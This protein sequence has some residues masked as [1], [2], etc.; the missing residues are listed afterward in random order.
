MQYKL[1]LAA[2]HGDII[3]LSSVVYAMALRDATAG[4][5]PYHQPTFNG[6][7]TGYILSILEEMRSGRLETCDGFGSAIATDLALI[8]AMQKNPL[9]I[10]GFAKLKKLNE[11][12][13]KRGDSFVISNEGL[14]WYDERGYVQPANQAIKDVKK[15]NDHDSSIPAPGATPY[16]W[17]SRAKEIGIE[18]A[19]RKT[20]LNLDQIA[21]KVQEKMAQLKKA[22]EAGVTGRGGKL[23]SAASIK[24]H[25]LKGIRQHLR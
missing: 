17:Q 3:P 10:V 13:E 11:W 19:K 22:G 16:Y 14:G 12:A 20:H 5:T 6:R 2:I 15:D 18:I 1:K 24:R 9:F 21:E 7:L 25:A 4:G 23:P 8:E